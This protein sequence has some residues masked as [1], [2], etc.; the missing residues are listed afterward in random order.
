MHHKDTKNTKMLFLEFECLAALG[1]GLVFFQVYLAP[2]LSA[3]AP[4]RE[5]PL[6]AP[7]APLREKEFFY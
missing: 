6:P 1:E 4:L 5:M 3:L 2:F 7:T